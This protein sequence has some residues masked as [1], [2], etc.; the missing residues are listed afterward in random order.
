[1]TKYI[2]PF[3]IVGPKGQ[4]IG[5]ESCDS[6][7]ITLGAVKLSTDQGNIT[8]NAQLGAY[9][10][11]LPQAIA[12]QLG[13]TPVYRVGV[14]VGAVTVYGS[15]GMLFNPQIPAPADTEV[16]TETT[17]VV[18]HDLPAKPKSNKRSMTLQQ[19]ESLKHR[20]QS[21]VNK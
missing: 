14:R 19:L 5:P 15:P 13:V 10:C 21:E 6:V 9:E 1:M 2:Y 7:E 11:S 12:T 16:Y 8:Y 20:V 3:H 4:L 17:K 18:I